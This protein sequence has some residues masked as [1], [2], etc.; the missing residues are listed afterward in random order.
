MDAKQREYNKQILDRI[1]TDPT[2]R[3]E[4]LN[5]PKGAFQR[6]G[7][8]WQG[9]S[10]EDVKGYGL[11]F[12][13]GNLLGG[14]VEGTEPSAMITGLVC[15]KEEP[16][17]LPIDPPPPPPVGSAVQPPASGLVPPPKNE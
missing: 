11:N 5:D 13:G 7:F 1:A 2:F 6:A 10:D 3:E 17:P 9:D 15:T 8:V 14:T 12:F 16:K 4:L